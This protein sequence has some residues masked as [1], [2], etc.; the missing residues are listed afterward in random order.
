MTFHMNKTLD[1][2]KKLLPY[3]LFIIGYCVLKFH[4]IWSTHTA[5]TFFSY[6]QDLFYNNVDIIIKLTLAAKVDDMSKFTIPQTDY[7]YD[8]NKDNGKIHMVSYELG[9]FKYLQTSQFITI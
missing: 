2:L 6:R 4:I 7:K 9:V 5:C 8:K 3:F 1:F